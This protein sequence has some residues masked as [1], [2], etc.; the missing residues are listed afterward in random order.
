LRRGPAG[1]FDAGSVLTATQPLVVGDE[2]WL[3]YTGLDGLH[4]AYPRKGYGA[5]AK[6]RLDGLASLSNG[7]FDPAVITTKQ[8]RVTG[9]TLLINADV[10]GSL[11]VEILDTKGNIINGFDRQ[12]NTTLSGNKLDHIGAWTGQTGLE[13]LMGKNVKL[14]F[15]LTG[16]DIYGFRFAT[17]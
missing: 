8:M 3:Y 9:P 15:Y 14:R 13:S 17:P 10:K 6:W 12:A 2:I 11:N 4:L 7:G 16:G 1:S 5:L